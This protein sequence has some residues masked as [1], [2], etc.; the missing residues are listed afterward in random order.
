M[1][2]RR[3]SFIE[4]V[5]EQLKATLE[6]NI[7]DGVCRHKGPRAAMF[8]LL[9]DNSSTDNRSFN[10]FTNLIIV[11]SSVNTKPDSQI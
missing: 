1:R 9:I 11:F 6:T 2:L 3:N 5:F 7:R 4:N 8:S 10:D